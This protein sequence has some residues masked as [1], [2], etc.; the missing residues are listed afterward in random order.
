MIHY[1][2]LHKCDKPY[3]NQCINSTSV[4][5]AQYII[6]IKIGKY[7]SVFIIQFSTEFM[8]CIYFL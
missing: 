6:I 2:I 1:N 4:Y 3:Y 7:I 5:L 8:C